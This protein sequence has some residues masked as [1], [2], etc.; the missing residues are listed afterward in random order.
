MFLIV[1]VSLFLEYVDLSD[2]NAKVSNNNLYGV[3]W[4]KENELYSTNI[5]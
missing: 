5:V 1:I 3:K 4:S 2:T